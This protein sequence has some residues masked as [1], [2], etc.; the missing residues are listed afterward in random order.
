LGIVSKPTSDVFT[1]WT[2]PK[3]QHL[4][5]SKWNNKAVSGRLHCGT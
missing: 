4:M 2:A 3:T 5:R 1:V